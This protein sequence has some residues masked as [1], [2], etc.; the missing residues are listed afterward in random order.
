MG[1]ALWFL[2]WLREFV[3]SLKMLKTVGEADDTS[4]SKL[5]NAGFTALLCHTAPLTGVSHQTRSGIRGVLKA[6]N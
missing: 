3:F 1:R 2:V 4:V 5:R 6:L